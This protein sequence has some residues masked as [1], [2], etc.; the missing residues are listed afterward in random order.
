MISAAF[1]LPMPWIYCSAISTRL[2]VGMFTPA[3]RAKDFS[4]VASPVRD[5][6][7]LAILFYRVVLS[8][9]VLSRV[10]LSR[11][12]VHQQV[13]TNANTTPFPLTNGARHRFE[14]IRL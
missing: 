14:T 1:F 8:R 4:P 2:L 10:V 11:A 6:A 12:G 9:V 7:I 13:S 3:I 5:V